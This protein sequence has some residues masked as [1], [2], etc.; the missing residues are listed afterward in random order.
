CLLLLLRREAG[1]VAVT[2]EVVDRPRE[3]IDQRP[4][5]GQ[6]D[7]GHQQ[8]RQMCFGE[9]LFEQFLR[10]GCLL[11]GVSGSN[12]YARYRW[13]K[14]GLQPSVAEGLQRERRR[15]SYWNSRTMRAP[16]PSS[17]WSDVTVTRSK[18]FAIICFA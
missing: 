5:A 15:A 11:D 1:G 14:R 2:E 6:M 16:P 4:V 7:G 8:R 18:P 9:T 3:L 10:H 13:G 17:C 12:S